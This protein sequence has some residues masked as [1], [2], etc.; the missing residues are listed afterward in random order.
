MVRRTRDACLVN[1]GRR[2]SFAPES[3]VG[4]WLVE[5]TRTGRG[6]RR[7]PG[8]DGHREDLPRAARARL[9]AI[10]VPLAT[11]VEGGVPGDRRPLTPRSTAVIIMY[12]K[13]LPTSRRR[14]KTRRKR[15]KR[16]S[17][18]PAEPSLRPRSERQETLAESVEMLHQI[19]QAVDL[20]SRQTLRD[21]GVT[22]PQI[23]A[24]RTIDDGDVVNM[25]DVAQRMYL[26]M[27]T[28]SGIID[29]LEAARLVTRDRSSADA[30]VMELRLTPRGRTLLAKA[31]E[32]P[33]S[34]AARGFQRLS[35]KELERVHSALLLVAHAMD[36]DLPRPGEPK[37]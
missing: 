3:G 21:F 34:K 7:R 36:V 37:P 24:L 8:R 9:E 5:P 35:P 19:F 28:V 17:R 27:S 4:G 15:V 1:S 2:A 26:H 12:T 22:G 14:P 30:R 23:W 10:T 31:P 20:F 32:P 13:Y 16:T 11:P 6:T 18:S 33:R 25:G 29:R